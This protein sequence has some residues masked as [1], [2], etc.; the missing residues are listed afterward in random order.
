MQHRLLVRR[1]LHWTGGWGNGCPASAYSS[2]SMRGVGV[3][4][5]RLVFIVV[6]RTVLAP[7]K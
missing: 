6:V 4:E 7:E 5:G 2:V 3:E 1:A